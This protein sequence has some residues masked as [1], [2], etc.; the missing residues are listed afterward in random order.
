LADLSTNDGKLLLRGNSNLGA[1]GV[2]VTTKVG[3][4]NNGAAYVDGWSGGD[5]GSDLTIGGELTNYGL[6]SEGN[7][8]LSAATSVSATEVLNYGTV[9]LQGSGGATATMKISGQVNNDYGSLT[10]GSGS[11]LSVSGQ[12]A[13]EASLTINAGA[14]LTITGTGDS[15]TQTGGTTTIAG[16][17]S[18]AV[19]VD[20]GVVDFTSALTSS[21]PTGAM[22]I[23]DGA[24]LEFAAG[25]DS[26]HTVTFA[27]T[28]GTLDLGS[29]GSF[30]SAI[31][32]FA[33]GDV[34]DL[35]G[36]AATSFTYASNVLDVYDNTTLVAAL[37]MGAG[38]SQASFSLASDG[39]NGTDVLD[40][41]TT[42][43]AAR[44]V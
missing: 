21:S 19:N 18:G 17:L 35:I 6:F 27:D 42:S 22:T 38:Y 10:L 11:T 25:A 36:T 30:A 7:G 9:G 13:N 39:A 4:T 5:G 24:T 8:S 16:A 20:G 15:Y 12:V 43:M 32:G 3:F 40:P 14:L 37:H 34:I 29:P 23:A 2:T 44:P 31:N 33:D 41:K 26:S 28:T 1:G